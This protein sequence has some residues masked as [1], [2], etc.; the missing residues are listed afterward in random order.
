MHFPPNEAE[1]RVFDGEAQM[2]RLLV[3]IHVKLQLVHQGRD[4]GGGVEAGTM[5]S[6]PPFLHHG[7]PQLSNTWV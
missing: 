1:E 4:R 3:L 5:V 2:L 7:I 6:L